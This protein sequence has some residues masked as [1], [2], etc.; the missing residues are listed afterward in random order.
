MPDSVKKYPNIHDSQY[1]INHFLKYKLDNST[2]LFSYYFLNFLL[3]YLEYDVEKENYVNKIPFKEDTKLERIYN[4]TLFY[5][6]FF[7][8]YESLI[9][10]TKFDYKCYPYSSFRE[11]DFDEIRDRLD[12]QIDSWF[13]SLSH[14]FQKFNINDFNDYEDL[15]NISLQVN[16]FYE[17]CFER[18]LPIVKEINY[19]WITDSDL[20]KTLL[21]DEDKKGLGDY[22][23]IFRILNHTQ[24]SDYLLDQKSFNM[25]F[26]PRFKNDDY[27]SLNSSIR[28][29]DINDIHTHFQQICTAFLKFGLIGDM[30]YQYHFNNIYI[31]STYQVDGPTD[32]IKKYSNLIKDEYNVY[33]RD[34]LARKLY[35]FCNVID[36]SNDIQGLNIDSLLRI[37][38]R[39]EP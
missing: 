22:A 16:P 4:A 26:E 20:V 15:K 29:F 39:H 7:C 14:S 3:W 11:W 9:Q 19:E 27:S 23:P 33:T 32:A 24:H 6:E 28:F 21:K 30:K 31:P 36:D 10:A 12:I 1:N 13:L 8:H 34:D 38:H 25:S 2:S 5:L 17:S 37:M 35:A 18:V